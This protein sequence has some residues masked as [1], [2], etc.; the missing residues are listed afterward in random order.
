V[1]SLW[2]RARR[3]AQSSRLDESWAVGGNVYYGVAQ[4]QDGKE[5]PGPYEYQRFASEIYKANGPVFALM[6]VR[7]MVFSEARF[8]F[9][10]MR[11]GRPGD[12]F[13]TTALEPLEHPWHGGTTGDLLSRMIQDADLY[14]NAF[15]TVLDDG[16]LQRLRPDWVQIL[17]GSYDEPTTPAEALDRE[18]VSYIYDPPSGNA[19]YLDPERV[20]HFAPIPDPEFSFRGMSWL[21]PV[22]REISAD[23]A[24]TVHKLKFFENG[25]TPQ[26]IVS[27]D[28]SLTSEQFQKFK[29]VMDA[30]HRGV[31]QAYKTLYLGGG[32]DVTIA[33][34]DLHQL[35]FKATQGAGETRLA[36][37]AG[38][39]SVIVGFSEGLA[40]S[41]LNAGNYAS[42]RRRFADGTMRPLWRN[43]AGSLAQLIDVPS[44]AELWFDDRDIAFLRDD[45]RDLADIQGLQ[46]RTIRQLVDAGYVPETVV[47]AVQA[48]DF[49]LMRHSGLYSVQLQKPGSGLPAGSNDTTTEGS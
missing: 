6:T 39:P 7:Q 38:V 25:A 46:S 4:A 3:P 47:A 32:A 14:G 31:D 26:V 30:S 37:A 21:T 20:A 34:K 43:V 41:S 9:R 45:A 12:L 28:A 24:A 5:R 49:S 13:G 2:Q 35:D 48:N 44:G 27:F 42:S 40:G 19:Q 33:G 16:R 11:N 15:V 22:L 18:L 8:Q 29:A 10:Q 17:M 36:A 1:T 23:Q